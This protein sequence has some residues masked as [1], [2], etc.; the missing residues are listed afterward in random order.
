MLN[1]SYKAY[2]SKQNK[3]LHRMINTSAWVWNHCI[4]LQKRYYRLYK[5]YINVNKLQ[6]HIAKLRNKKQQW[7]ALNSQ[8]VQ[9]ICQ[10]VDAAY[11]RFFKKLAKRP[12]KFKK[13]K[14]FKSFVLKTSGWSVSE[15]KLTINKIGVF[16]FSKSRH[17]EKIKRI[18]VKR[19][20]LGDIY[21]VFACDMQPL[22]YKRE[23]Q[24]SIGADFGLKTYLTLS[25]EQKEESPRFFNEHQKDVRKANKNLSTKQKESNNRKKAKQHLARVHKN[26]ANK[27]NDF[28]WQLAHKLC[29]Q[30]E[31]IAIEDLNIEAM[32]KLWGKKI[33][34]LSFSAFV[35]ILEQVALKYG[36]VIQKIGRF[37][38]SSKLCG[39]GTIN[40][41]LQ[42]SDRAW[43]CQ[44]CGAINQRDLLAANNILSEGIRLYRT[45]HKT[46]VLEAA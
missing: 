29:K 17:H 8:T 22:R 12:P 37:Y 15:N 19:D 20:A 44:S 1:I 26:I 4:A 36:T 40:K 27:R 34:D 31:F 23:G 10:R 33:S 9:E 32:K 7:K 43:T 21:F 45:K 3:K 6:K 24:S 42:L 35:R 39:C 13:A 30:N 28:H 41:E 25:N 11:R 5:K 18:S 16:K 2:K 38:P 14:N 46:S